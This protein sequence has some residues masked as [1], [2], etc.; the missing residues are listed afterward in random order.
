MV[1]AVARVSVV[2]V[3]CGVLAV[4]L[5]P[6]PEQAAG[7]IRQFA[8]L[9]GPPASSGR[10]ARAYYG[11]DLD[12]RARGALPDVL[13]ARVPQHSPRLWRVAVLSQY[14]GTTWRAGPLAGTTAPTAVADGYDVQGAMGD[15][16]ETPG[17]ATTGTM[18]SFEVR[19]L[20]GRTRMMLAPGHPQSVSLSS[21][22]LQ[23]WGS[24]RLALVSTGAAPAADRYTV[25]TLLVPSASQVSGPAVAASVPP[26]ASR[27]TELPPS[28]TQRTRDL[29]RQITATAGTR[30]EQVAA[31][32][33]FLARFPYTLDSA[34]PPTGQDAVDHFLFEAKEGF[35]EQFASA[36]VV[37]L[38]SLG[39]PARMATGFSADQPAAGSRELRSSAAHAWVEVLQPGVGWTPSDPTPPAAQSS[40]PSA[41]TAF[42]R[43]VLADQR[44]R[45][46]AAG[47]VALLVAGLLVAG[48]VRRRPARPVAVQTS[49]WR[50]TAAWQVVAALDLL[51]QALEQ[52]GRAGTPGETVAELAARVPEVSPDV[53]R[54]AEAA[55][56][57]RVPLRPTELDRVVQALGAGRVV[58]LAPQHSPPL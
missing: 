51:R 47:A 55:L 4:L 40:G 52:A 42:V 33:R 25:R 21:G 12:L 14:D 6:V 13:I 19:D 39:V 15:E 36:E 17:A 27:W 43:H 56:Y 38:R 41:L 46:L 5:V 49:Q 8:G 31:I 32:E 20:S 2:T 37:L 11:G 53:M 28:T 24:S 29:A 9:D 50:P 23:A 26:V 54:I 58:V 45:Y 1:A 3:L 30:G 22:G 10:D 57:D 35:C 44:L 48:L 7:G 18:A 34:V 16:P